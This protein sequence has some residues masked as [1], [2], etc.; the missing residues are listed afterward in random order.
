MKR[1]RQTHDLVEIWWDDA[2]EL[3]AGWRED[4]DEP[5]PMLALSVGFLV[6]ETKDHI[7]LAQ[8]TD[9]Q[10]SHNGRGQI[11]K[12]MVKKMKVLRKRD[13]QKDG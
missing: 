10:G 12:G 2:T 5:E 4:V 11:P 7:I 9:G 8:D 13:T 3:E 1:P 6:W